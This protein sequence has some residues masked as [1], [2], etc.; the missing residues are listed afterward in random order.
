MKTKKAPKKKKTDIDLNVYKVI[1]EETE[2]SNASYDLDK[3]LYTYKPMPLSNARNGYRSEGKLKKFSKKN[4]LYVED[5]FHNLHVAF[6]KGIDTKASCI[7][8]KAMSLMKQEHRRLLCDTFAKVLPPAISC[9]SYEEKSAL[10]FNI[11]YAF[12]LFFKRM[13]GDIIDFVDEYKL[14]EDKRRERSN[15]HFIAFRE[16]D[17]FFNKN[18]DINYKFAMDSLRLSIEIEKEQSIRERE[19]G[20]QRET[21]FGGFYSLLY[22][23]DWN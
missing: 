2:Y 13:N 8:Y 15:K 21:H 10:G 4:K 22:E 23:Y 1:S 16:H 3:I 18:Y 9:K 5:I 12:E 19:N 14:S 11:E 17:E 20:K 6:R 7:A